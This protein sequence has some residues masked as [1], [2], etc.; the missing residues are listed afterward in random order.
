MN[1]CYDYVGYWRHLWAALQMQ[2]STFDDLVH[3]QAIYTQNCTGHFAVSFVLW[4]GL[5]GCFLH[6]LSS[7]IGTT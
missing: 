7:L 3:L 4:S 5:E 6:G 2:V 1:E